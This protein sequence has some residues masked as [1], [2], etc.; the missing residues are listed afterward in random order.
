[1][2]NTRLYTGRPW[3]ADLGALRLPHAPIRTPPSAASSAPTPSA[4]TATGTTSAT[5]TATSETTPARLP[6]PLGLW[7]W[8][9]DFIEYGVGGLIGVRGGQDFSAAWSGATEFR[10]EDYESMEELVSFVPFVG[11]GADADLVRR[12]WARG[13]Y[14]GVAIGAVGFIPGAGDAAS[15]IFRAAHKGLEAAN[16]ISDVARPLAKTA[17][18]ASDTLTKAG[19]AA[20]NATEVLRKHPGSRGGALG[21]AADAARRGEPP[22]QVAGSSPRSHQPGATRKTA[23]AGENGSDA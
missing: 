12:D 4:P 9:A 2:N 11:W 22:R 6:D 14:V 13:D 16:V 18:T 8:D 23:I 5:P 10:T 21:D 17:D 20:E 7:G 1:M 19:K 15:G 3:N